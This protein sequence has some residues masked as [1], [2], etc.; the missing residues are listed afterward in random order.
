MINTADRFFGVPKCRQ[1]TYLP[2]D[3]NKIRYVGVEAPGTLTIAELQV[4]DKSGK[5]VALGKPV[6]GTMPGFNTKR[7]N[8][9]NGIV[10]TNMNENADLPIDQRGYISRADIRRNI[11]NGGNNYSYVLID[12]GD[13][14]GNLHGGSITLFNRSDANMAAMIDAK[15]YFLNGAG[16]RIWTS[17][18]IDRT[19][20]TYTWDIL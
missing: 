10:N 3:D 8:I 2:P 7:A 14:V 13:R 12:L 9:N 18:P 11:N 16:R 5:N 20:Y 17:D 15:V 1:D 6:E 19:E 4:K